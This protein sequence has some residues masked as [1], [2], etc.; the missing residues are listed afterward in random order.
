MAVAVAVGFADPVFESQHVFR[1]VMDALARPGSINLLETGVRPP[2]PLPAGLAAVAL[3]LA[4]HDAPIWLDAALCADPAVAGYL[5]FHTGAPVVADPK[6]AALALVGDPTSCASLSSFAVGTPE[7]PDRS[8]TI[9]FAV[10]DLANDEGGLTLEG[11]GIAARAS[12]RASPLP[13]QFPA[14]IDENSRLFPR[15][16]DCLFVAPGRIAGLPRTTRLVAEI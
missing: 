6:A 10:S 11:P 1:S 9:V 4:D 2:A 12:L 8:T 5:R 7:Y 16:V 15:G 14:Q 3:A 13:P